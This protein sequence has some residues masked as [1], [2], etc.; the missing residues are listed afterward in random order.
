[1][2]GANR[3]GSLPPLFCVLQEDYEF[4][5]LAAALGPQQ[6]VYAFRSLAHVNDYDE[7]LIQALALRYVSHIQRAHPYGALFLLGYCQACKIAI[8][9]AQHLL[10]RR[11]QTIRMGPFGGCLMQLAGGYSPLSKTG[12]ASGSPEIV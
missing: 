10:R 2:L 12:T 6:P 3:D 11:R 7:D 1:M 8:P 5:Y 4:R 9:M